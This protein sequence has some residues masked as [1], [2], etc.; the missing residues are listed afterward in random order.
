MNKMDVMIPRTATGVHAPSWQKALSGAIS[1]VPELLA[2]TGNCPEAVKQHYCIPEQFPIRVPQCYVERIAP[3]D[4]DDP[5][6]RQVLSYSEEI[7]TTPGY[8]NDPLNEADSNILPGI[9]HKYH[10]RVLLILGAACAIHCRYCFRRH[11]DYQNNQNSSLQWLPALDYIRN[12]PTITE[13]I[14]SGGDPLVNSDKKLARLTRQIADIAHVKRLR[15][16]TRVPVVIPQRVTEELV[17]WMTESRLKISLVLH[18]NHANEIDKEVMQVLSLLSS[19]QIMLLNQSVLLKG[20]NDRPE[21][22]L[23]LSEKLFEA[24]VLPYYLH[25]MD[26]VQ[27][28][29]HYDTELQVA[30]DLHR[31]MLIRLPGY[32]VPKLV[33]EEPGKDS[34]TPIRTTV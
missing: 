30:R 3:G 29:A 23:Q 17:D 12:N 10:G 16:H 34:K 33:V 15:I 13:V 4:I 1:S 7:I 18:I 11:F 19:N 2:A 8:T 32:L 26:K 27:H 21:T 25:L 9:I 31:E 22:L 24:G 14:Y 6:L 5:L 28:A 20:V